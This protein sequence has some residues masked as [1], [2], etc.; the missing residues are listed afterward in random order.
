[1]R[2]ADTLTPTPT[3]THAPA[4]VLTIAYGPS[5]AQVGDL[6]LPTL[7]TEAVAAGAARP[8]LPAICL[9]HGGFWRMPWGRDH[10]AP[11]A[12]DFAQR[13]FVVWNLEY[14]RVGA[15]GGGWPGTLQD[16]VSGIE[17]LATMAAQGVA[18]DLDRVTVL[19][20]SAGGHLALWAAAALDRRRGHLAA[21]VGLAPVADLVLA[22][23]LG[24]GSGAV[25]D[26]LGGSP[27]DQRPRYESASPAL[28]LP[29]GIRQL[30]IHGTHDDDVPVEISRRYVTASRAAGDDIEFMELPGV[31]HMELVSPQ[32]L[33]HEALCGWLAPAAKTLHHC[34]VLGAE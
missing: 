28:R 21:A 1:M 12:A 32:G 13:G 30:I 27:Q 20:H 9:L 18:L 4:A 7:D 26:F 15:P 10:I 29:L 11:L 19:G 3:P 24:C 23:E 25:R 8:T 33:A 16:V 17:H 34:G 6:Y 2:H 22:H 31:S 5:P 14:R